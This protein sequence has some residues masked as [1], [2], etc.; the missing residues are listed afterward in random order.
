MR[1]LSR[2]HSSVQF[3][4]QGRLL[5][6]SRVSAAV[7]G[8]RAEHKPQAQRIVRCTCLHNHH[9]S[10]WHFQLHCHC[11]SSLQ[12]SGG[13]SWGC[14]KCSQGPQLS[15]VLTSPLW[16][17]LLR[18]LWFYAVCRAVSRRFLG[19]FGCYH[20]CRCPSSLLESGRGPWSCQITPRA[21]N[22]HASYMLAPLRFS[23]VYLC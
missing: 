12:E 19:R 2:V 14:Q 20:N 17:D 22:F 13:G 9:D 4:V 16:C 11:P 21:L 1:S 15:C 7:L 18:S 10:V 5:C 23:A 3:G 6:T 8:V